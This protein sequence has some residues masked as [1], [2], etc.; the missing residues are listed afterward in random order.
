MDVKRETWKFCMRAQGR[1]WRIP[2][3]NKG[4]GDVVWVFTVVYGV[5]WRATGLEESGS[6]E[7]VIW[8]QDKRSSGRRVRG[9]SLGQ[10]FLGNMTRR[11][12]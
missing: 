10:M 1:T 11:E 7:K 5:C 12:M 8:R 9:L 4:H 3:V 6:K 2:A